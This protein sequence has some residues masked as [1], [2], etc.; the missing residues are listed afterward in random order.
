MS[1]RIALRHVDDLSFWGTLREAR[2]F[3]YLKDPRILGT[4][5]WRDCVALKE[6]VLRRL[7]E[8]PRQT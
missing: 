4:A 2:A 3:D 8:N 5:L 6:G 7:K 1:Q